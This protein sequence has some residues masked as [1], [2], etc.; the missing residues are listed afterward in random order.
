MFVKDVKLLHWA[1][2]HK[3]CSN[4]VDKIDADGLKISTIVGLSRGGLVP[5]TMLAHKLNVREVMVHGYHS[6]DEETKSRDAKNTHGMMYQDVMYD[7]MASC[8]GR[9][10]LVVDDLCDQ[11]LT[12][13]GLVSRM[14]KKFHKGV[15]NV[16]TA[17]LYCKTH[18]TFI[19][20][21]TGKEVGPDWL[22][23]PW[24]RDI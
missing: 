16:L 5:A 7:L 1:D 20:T 17:A 8:P 21:Y 2:I 24:E 3:C 23:F 11:G 19:P 13:K 6:Y 14:Y 18:S 4:I 9:N 12:M 15:V 10:I 22:C